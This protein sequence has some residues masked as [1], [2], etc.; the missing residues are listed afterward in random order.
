MGDHARAAQAWEEYLAKDAAGPWSD[1]ARERLR[2]AR[3]STIRERT[4]T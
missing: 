2:R 1:E 4:L 3:E